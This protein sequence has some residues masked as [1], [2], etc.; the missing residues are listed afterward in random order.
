[1]QETRIGLD[2][3]KR[4]FQVHSVDEHRLQRDCSPRAVSTEPEMQRLGCGG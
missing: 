4:V 2:I 1:M 3:A